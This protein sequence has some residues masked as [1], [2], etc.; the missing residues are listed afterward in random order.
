MNPSIKLAV[1]LS[2]NWHPRKMFASGDLGT[3]QNGSNLLS[4][5]QDSLGMTAGAVSSAAGWC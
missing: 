3:I 2:S 4:V 1:L 5:Y